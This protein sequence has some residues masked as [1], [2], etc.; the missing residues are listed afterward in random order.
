[1]KV[2]LKNL[3]DGSLRQI[4]P[5]EFPISIGR[6]D[7][8]ALQIDDRWASRLHCELDLVD[9]QLM[10]SDLRSKHGTLINGSP[11]TESLLESEDVLSVGLTA[12]YVSIEVTENAE[13]FEAASQQN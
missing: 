8:A 7:Q 1:M 12:F 4:L 5:D 9:G 6:G 2:I 10:V 13:N 3:E 11:V